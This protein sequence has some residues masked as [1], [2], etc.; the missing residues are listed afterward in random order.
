MSFIFF[1]LFALFT[2]ACALTMIFCKNPV[3]SALA[4]LGS[5]IGLAALFIQINAYL[6]GILQILVYAGAIIV[7]FLFIIM[8]LDI[9]REE[10]ITR[11]LFSGFLGAII[12][13]FFIL[14]I[15]SVLYKTP[16][17]PF[18]TLRFSQASQSYPQDSHIAKAL[19]ENRLP[20]THL[21]GQELFTQHP[22]AV[23]FAGIL[24]LI[25]TVGCVTLSLRQS[26]TH[27]P[28]SK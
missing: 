19:N 13:S 17:L 21:I 20:D 24:I 22:Y 23:Q 15:V 10:R 3:G 7:L 9:P 2:V 28:R 27:L 26:S 6:L 1:Y 18:P 16:S 4:M 12:A 25:A 8:L 14:Q 11:N 5:F